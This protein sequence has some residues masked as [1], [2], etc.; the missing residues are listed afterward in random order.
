MLW[1]WK[2][3]NQCS[4]I[5]KGIWVEKDEYVVR[6]RLHELNLF[7]VSIRKAVLS[8]LWLEF[9]TGNRKRYWGVIARKMAFMLTAG[10][11]LLSVLKVI[12]DREST[13]LH[14]SQWMKVADSLQAG[15]D[16]A[17]SIK[18][19]I[20]TPG[21]F[22]YAMLQAGEKSGT[23]AE[24]L[25]D[26]ADYLEEQDAFEKKIRGTLFYPLLL[27]ITAVIVV[28]V[29]SIMILPM[30]QKLF[31][32]L[33]AELPLAT[34]IMFQIGTVIPYAAVFLVISAI[35]FGIFT[36]KRG[37]IT[38]PGTRHINRL[39]QLIQF[40]SIL[41]RLL[42]AGLTLQDALILQGTI[43]RDSSM[44]SLTQDLIQ[45]VS[46]GQRLSS[47]IMSYPQFPLEAAKIFEVAEE[48]GKIGEM[49]GFLTKMFK[50][51]LQANIYKYSRLLEPILILGMAGVVG[52]VAIGVL[53]PVFDVSSYIK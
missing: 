33:D 47:V 16:F 23:L 12:A 6:F 22:F 28:Y 19:V 40:C 43:T 53:L 20:P 18:S 9:N 21:E 13:P 1:K 27:M 4:Q 5:V 11:P 51:E 30:Y 3:I 32:G 38:M 7:P 46:Q 8:T 45:A 2:A 41:E 14:K 36:Y 31:A 39:W 25:G 26:I 37:G 10:I 42:K 49:L 48:S 50:Q 44:E 52:F 17:I 34:K 29:L 35:I 15:E 24:S